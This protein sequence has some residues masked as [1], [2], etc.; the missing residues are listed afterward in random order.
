MVNHGPL[1]FRVIGQVNSKQ[2]S[3]GTG[4][5]RKIPAPTRPHNLVSNCPGF[6]SGPANDH[7]HLHS[8]VRDLASTPPPTSRGAGSGASEFS[9]WRR[10]AGHV[11]GSGLEE[12]DY[13]GGS[14]LQTCR[15]I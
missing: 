5:E 2:R 6:F 10:Y 8:Q 12:A 3:T 4:G 13:R 14:A 7:P 9:F 1:P 15:V 11:A